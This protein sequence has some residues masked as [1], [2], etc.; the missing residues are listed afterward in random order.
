VISIKFWVRQSRLKQNSKNLESCR[1]GKN[2]KRRFHPQILDFDKNESHFRGFRQILGKTVVFKAKSEKFGK[3]QKW[4]N[5]DFT[6]CWILIRKN[7]IFVIFIK[8]WVRQSCLKLNHT[9]W[10][11][12]KNGKMGKRRFHPKILEFG[13]NE[14]HF[15]DFHQVLGK[16]VVFK[17]KFEK[18]GKLQKWE[19]AVF[20]LNYWI[21]IRKNHI[22]VIF[23]KFWVRQSCLKQNSKS[24]ESCK[25]GKM[26]KRRL[27][28]Q[29]LDFDQ[30]ESHF[31]DFHQILGQTVVFKAKS[32]KLGKLQKMGKMENA[33]F[34]LKYWI[35]VKMNH[36]FV[37][38]VKFWVRK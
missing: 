10:E 13:Q 2:G 35:L 4:E 17:A 15:R 12:C 22:F 5:A 30:E 14:S 18:F 38:F 31:C 29:L 1:N 16:T 34:T 37:V 24:L 28:P 23:I 33:D 21:L 7:H 6:L 20:T 25:N 26:G 32:H 11:S 8:F 9:S 19:N 3:L 36:F 27:H